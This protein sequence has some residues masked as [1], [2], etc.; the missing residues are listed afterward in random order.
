MLC[1]LARGPSATPPVSTPFDCT[2][3]MVTVVSCFSDRHA[4]SSRDNHVEF[5]RRTQAT[6]CEEPISSSADSLELG[7]LFK[8]Q[9]VSDR[10]SQAAENEVLIFATENALFV[11]FED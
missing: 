6:H 8:Y 2:Y 9:M 4:T 1:P 7:V 11:R 5:C 10:L 3:N